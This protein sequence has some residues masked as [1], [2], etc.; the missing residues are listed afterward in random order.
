MTVIGTNVLAPLPFRMA[1]LKICSGP[2]SHRE[3]NSIFVKESSF[4]YCQS[5]IEIVNTFQSVIRAFGL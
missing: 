2:G 3:E 5:I 4:V 1:I